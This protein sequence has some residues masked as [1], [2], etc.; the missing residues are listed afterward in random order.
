MTYKLESG[1]VDMSLESCIL[2]SEESIESSSN[3]IN[4]QIS[5]REVEV[6]F[7]WLFKA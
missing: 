5:P 7:V 4:I 3:I 6:K 2:V 1:A